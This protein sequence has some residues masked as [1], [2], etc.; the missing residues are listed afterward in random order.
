MRTPPKFLRLATVLAVAAAGVAVAADL[1]KEG[2]FDVTTCF[3][4][5]SHRIDF[6]DTQFAYSY[7]EYGVALSNPPGGL[8]DYDAVRCV[9]MTANMDGMPSGGS[10]CEG[11]DKDGNR[12]LNRFVYDNEGR[13]KREMIGGTG[14]YEGMVLGDTKYEALGPFPT[15]KEGHPFTCNRQTGNYKLK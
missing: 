14:K 9:G 2:R 11:V 5:T 10:V 3:S 15:M 1:P 8:F 4:R 13:I 6:S 7:E 12:R